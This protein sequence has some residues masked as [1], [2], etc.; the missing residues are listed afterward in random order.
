[1]VQEALATKPQ[2]FARQQ[3]A[4]LVQKQVIENW[5]SQDEPEHLRTIRDRL[6]RNEKRASQ[7]LSLYQRILEKGELKADDGE[8]HIELRLSGLAIKQGTALHVHNRIYAAVFNAGWVSNTLDQLRPYAEAFNAW[9]VSEGKDESRLLRGQA[10]EEALQWAAGRNL[11]SQDAEFLRASQQYES[12]LTKQKFNKTRQRLIALACGSL[13]LSLSGLLGYSRVQEKRVRL[14][15]YRYI[16]VEEPA[17]AARL[18]RPLVRL[19]H[20]LAVLDLQRAPFM[21]LMLQGEWDELVTS[22]A[23]TNL[24]LKADYVA[25]PSADG[26]PFKV[27]FSPDGKT[28]ATGSYDGVQLW[29]RQGQPLGGPLPFGFFIRKPYIQPISFSSDGELIAGGAGNKGIWVWNRQGKLLAGGFGNRGHVVRLVAISSD[30]QT[31]VSLEETFNP[32]A[33][34]IVQLWDTEGKPIKQLLKKSEEGIKPVRGRIAEHPIVLDIRVHDIAISPDGKTISIVYTDGKVEFLNRE[35][36]VIGNIQMLGGFPTPSFIRPSTS[37]IAFSPDGNLIAIGGRRLKIWNINSQQP[38]GE[39]FAPCD[40]LG[41]TFDTNGKAIAGLCE[42]SAHVWTLQE[43]PDGSHSIAM[44]ASAEIPIDFRS[45]TF[46]LDQEL[47]VIGRGP[48]SRERNFYE[49]SYLEQENGVLYF[50]DLQKRFADSKTLD[51]INT[52]NTSHAWDLENLPRFENATAP[53]STVSLR[54]WV[55]YTCARLQG[56]LAERPGSS[57]QERRVVKHARRTCERYESMRQQ[58]PWRWE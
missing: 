58:E 36:D 53:D 42:A 9:G 12:Q 40:I 46:S 33:S 41:I 49:Q 16:A 7:L 45:G 51:T 30:S 37:N 27:A 15:K 43:Q 28:I 44:T 31:I 55:T 14:E 22:L 10:L 5:E 56:Y 2:N 23:D 39:I 8:G 19:L 25:S 4:Q 24:Q 35:G 54:H 48:L 6:L 52:H 26:V 21:Q 13:I 32:Y 50:F 20:G 47:L 29:D 57:G 11:S 1:M 17:E 3:V 18:E 38:L 34:V